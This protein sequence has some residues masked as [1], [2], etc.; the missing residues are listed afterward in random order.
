MI[1]GL[2][3]HWTQRLQ[4]IHG[5]HCQN[6]TLIWSHLGEIFAKNTQTSHIIVLLSP[7]AEEKMAPQNPGQ[8]ITAPYITHVMLAKQ[9]HQVDSSTFTFWLYPTR[10]CTT[11]TCHKEEHML[12]TKLKSRC[13]CHTV[14]APTLWVTRLISFCC[15]RNPLTPRRLLKNAGCS[16]DFFLQFETPNRCLLTFFEASHSKWHTNKIQTTPALYRG[17]CICFCFFWKVR[18]WYVSM[19]PGDIVRNPLKMSQSRAVQIIIYN[20]K[21][22]TKSRFDW[23]PLVYFA[24]LIT[25]LKITCIIR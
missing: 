10:T 24:T 6:M 11:R 19:F 25:H 3:I 21:A 17:L 18:G 15:R 23:W 4:Q 13:Q 22:V 1:Y 9:A 12:S 2:S 20:F 5:A 16:Y 7:N 8:K 14:I